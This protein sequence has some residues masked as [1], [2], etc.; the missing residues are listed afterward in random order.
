MMPNPVCC[1]CFTLNNYVEDEL[2]A[3]RAVFTD[4][5]RVRYAIF[6]KEVGE[7]GT[8]H[9]QG[10]V[11]LKKKCRMAGIKLLLG[12]RAHVEPAKGNE[13][14][15]IV[16]CS[17]QGDVEEFGKRTFK[18]KRTDLEAFKESVKSGTYDHTI[19]ME[20][21]SVVWSRYPVFCK[22]YVRLN[23]PKFLVPCHP[24]RAWQQ[25]LLTSL[26]GDPDDRSIVFVVDIKGNSGKT[27]F[28]KYYCQ[29]HSD[30][31][32]LQPGKRADMAY[33][34]PDDPNLRVV[35]LDCPKSKQGEFIQY[36]FLEN[37][38]DRDV[39][40]PKYESCYK[41][42]GPLHVVVMTNELPEKDKLIADR[43]DIIKVAP[44]GS[45]YSRHPLEYFT[46]NY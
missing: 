18:G 42:Y 38:K 35:F 19:L 22:E 3:L 28:T 7:S 15:N 23:R 41:S 34:L 30:A 36:D 31:F 9:L 29:H 33:C 8:P 16:Y 2:V 21:H 39:F 37:L 27:W 13:Q 45:S 1:W 40:S 25:E 46:E 14:Q 5:D 20:E 32:K 11:S 10:Y 17:K 24:L 6:G 12:D 43:F 4:A 26:S 44:D